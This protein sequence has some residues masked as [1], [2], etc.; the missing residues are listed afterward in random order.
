MKRLVDWLKRRNWRSLL[1]EMAIL[2]AI[3]VAIGAWQGRN[4]VGSGGPAPA[5]AL[6]TLDGKPFDLASLRGQK[7][8]VAFWAPWCGVC[9]VEMPTLNA[10]AKDGV[11]V[12]GVALS[13][14]DVASVERFASEHDLAFP[15]LLGD[16]RTGPAWKVDAYPTLYIV[17][18][19]GRI[20]H[21]VVGYTTGLGLRLRLL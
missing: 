2:A 7:A 10:L 18:E 12:I 8:V 11:P 1:R 20:E 5:L 14:P 21:A 4:L 6:H 19:E 3:L 13:Y 15:V 16:E 9:K 17:D